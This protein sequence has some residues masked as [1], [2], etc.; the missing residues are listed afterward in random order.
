MENDGEFSKSGMVVEDN[1]IS[2]IRDSSST[3]VAKAGPR[4]ATFHGWMYKHYFHVVSEDSKNLRV[5]CI[6]CGGGNT[7]SSTTN[8][9][10]NFKER[11]TA[12]HKNTKL[13]AKEIEKPETEKRWRRSNTD[14]S[15]PKRFARCISQELHRCIEDAKFAL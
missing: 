2:L 15:E 12:V 9:T 4:V 11:L 6:L 10:S 3:E 8:I 13:V 1:S 7:F 5:H 14:D